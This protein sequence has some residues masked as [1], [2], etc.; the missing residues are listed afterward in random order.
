M[1]EPFEQPG[2]RDARHGRLEIGGAYRPDVG[3]QENV[4]TEAFGSRQTNK[5]FG[6]KAGSL[7]SRTQRLLGLQGRLRLSERKLKK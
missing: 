4:G 1:R 7:S 3:A 6:R 5:V 2:K